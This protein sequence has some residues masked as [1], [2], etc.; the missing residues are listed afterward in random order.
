MGWA[1]TLLLGDIGNQ[2]DIEDN[3]EIID[4][5]LSELKTQRQ[6]NEDH[7]HRLHELEQENQQLKTSL[8]LMVHTLCQKDILTKQELE[9]FVELVETKSG[10]DS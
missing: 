6:A 2:L 4:Y 7:N 3:G 5:L 10:D 1:R 9:A 8:A